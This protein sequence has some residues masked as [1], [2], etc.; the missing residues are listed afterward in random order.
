M[1]KISVTGPKKDMRAAIEEL[2]EAGVMDI[3]DYSGELETGESFEEGD[4]LSELLV[5]IRSILS[6]LPE[7]E[8]DIETSIPM[9]DLQETVK[10]IAEKIE[11]LSEE[12]EVLNSQ[13]K[14][15]EGKVEFFQKLEGVKLDYSDLNG[16]QTLDAV[17]TDITEKEAEEEINPEIEFFEGDEL[18]VVIFERKHTEEVEAAIRRTGN[19]TYAVPDTEYSGSIKEIVSYLERDL[20]EIKEEKKNIESEIDTLAE[21]NYTKLENTE[22]F[23]TEKVE[24][25]EAPLRFATTDHAFIVKGWVPTE[26]YSDVSGR[27]DQMSNGRIHIQEEEVEEEETPPVE[28]KNNKAVQPFESLTDLVS[29][30]TYNELDPSFV[31]LLTFPLFFGFMIGDAGYGIT[32]LAVFYG[33]YKMFPGAKNIFKSLMYASVATIAFGLAFGDAFGYVIFGGHSELAAATGIALFKEIPILWHRA[34]HL[35]QVFYISA[36]IGLVH[37]NAG[38]LLGAYNEFINHGLKE[39]VLE[40]GSWMLL[41]AGAIIAVLQNTNIGLALMGLS[42]VMLLKGEGVEGVVEIPSLLS[43]ILSYFRIF[44]VSVAAVSLA[45]VVNAMAN[46]LLVSGSAFGLVAGVALLMVGHIFNTF[47]KILE[48]FLQGIRL[49]YVEMFDKFYEGGGRKYSPFGG[50]R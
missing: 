27:L 41:Q 14:E 3:E 24:K 36:V 31:L 23:L 22:E 44:G 46:P 9:E 43:N 2:H 32:S 29:R 12:K 49:H 26:K 33:G 20:G 7:K 39:A 21:K 13:R 8:S 50:D 42:L 34:E 28:H 38:Y 19:E 15:V 30:P 10:E 48:G 5:D 35:T 6:K 18:N 40:K 4:E 11:S 17:V 25:A 47:I 16:S 37:V 45:Q 1:S